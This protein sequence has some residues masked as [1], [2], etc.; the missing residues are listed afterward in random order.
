ME[1]APDGGSS[2]GIADASNP[3]VLI[4]TVDVG[5]GRTERIEIRQRD[6]PAELARAFCHKHGLPPTIVAPLAHHLIENLRQAGQSVTG[7]SGSK[8]ARSGRSKGGAQPSQ[9]SARSSSSAGAEATSHGADVSARAREQ[10]D[11]AEGSV[12]GRLY[13]QAWEIK[14]KI[15]ERKRVLEQQA[16]EAVA[17]QRAGMSW[18][19]QEM[20]RDRTSGPFDNYGEMLYAESLESRARRVEMTVKHKEEVEESEVKGLTF[21][22]AIST[23]AR[24]LWAKEQLPAWQRLSKPKKTKTE[25]RLEQ[26]RQEK[27]VAE[28]KECTFRPKINNRSDRLMS[29]RSETM[30]NLSI[31]AHDQ[32]FQDA[33]RR[34][35][36]QAEYATLYPEDAT[37]Q[38][39]LIETNVSREILRRSWDRMGA[40]VD[41]AGGSGAAAR[42]ANLTDRLYQSYEKLQAKLEEARHKLD[43]P[44]D[45]QTGKRLYHPQTGRAPNFKRNTAGQPIGEYLYNLQYDIDE[46]RESVK[47][48]V[49]ARAHEEANAHKT[50]GHSQA[51]IRKLKR[52]RFRQVFDYLDQTQRGAI[53]LAAV[54]A[55]PAPAYLDNLDDEVRADLELAARLYLKQRSKLGRENSGTSSADFH[56]PPPP[57]LDLIATAQSNKQAAVALAALGRGPS[58]PPTPATPGVVIFDRFCQFME[59]AL[60]MRRGPRTYLAPSPPPKYTPEESFQPKI[61]ERSKQLAA[62]LRPADM[63]VYEVLHQ[64]ATNLNTK[65]EAKRREQA[66]ASL[67]GCTFAPHLVAEQLVKEGKALRC[68]KQ[69]GRHASDSMDAE[70]DYYGVF[71][72]AAEE[73]AASATA[74]EETGSDRRTA[75][76]VLEEDSLSGNAQY[77]MAM[78]LLEDGKYEALEQEVQ[79]M[80]TATSIAAAAAER[81]NNPHSPEKAMLGKLLG[82]EN[83]EQAD[84]ALEAA[85]ARLEAW[86]SR[87]PQEAQSAG[88]RSQSSSVTGAAGAAGGFGGSRSA[89]LAPQQLAEVEAAAAAAEDSLARSNFSAQHVSYAAAASAHAA[90]KASAGQQSKS[91]KQSKRSSLDSNASQ[92]KPKYSEVAAAASIPEDARAA[93]LQPGP[94]SV[95]PPPAVPDLINLNSSRTPRVQGG[96]EG[97]QQQQRSKPDLFELAAVDGTA[98]MI[99]RPVPGTGQK[100]DAAPAAPTAVLADAR[101]GLE[102]L[103]EAM[104]SWDP[105][106]DPNMQRA[107]ALSERLQQLLS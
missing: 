62:R 104:A 27:E 74:D 29:E 78:H 16:D 12:F 90:R 47:Q 63:P 98:V 33:V 85:V 60:T 76:H 58:A 77:E 95:P 55:E 20:M 88:H 22:P 11:D 42:R 103:A 82:I 99:T 66:D 10:H 46:H 75:R 102:D 23:H 105:A 19:S 92:R 30:K 68:L 18:I 34:Q 43:G 81:L 65:M 64:E 83:D 79:E 25:E 1:V 61:S 87:Q 51:L 71:D 91:A 93:Q 5:E 96:V 9:G 101:S 2:P 37:F 54:L 56:M 3:I 70:A 48:E 32:L 53:D 39:K 4:T 17:Q 44:N 106:A 35:L 59:A 40:S 80:L 41:S 67:E 31:R 21:T 69:P 14:Q 86:S 6:E 15:Q 94:L 52:K 36:R 7:K 97:Q 26:L 84:E 28:V 57:T 72:A 50:T 100:G 38:P 73:A 24:G 8:S 49:Q 45:P 107:D 13:L 89:S